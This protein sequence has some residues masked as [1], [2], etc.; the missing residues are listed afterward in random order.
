MQRRE[1]DALVR[2][3]DMILVEEITKVRG[4]LKIILV[5]VVKRDMLIKKVTKN[6]ESPFGPKLLIYME[7]TESMM[8]DMLE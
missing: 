4:G 3:S 1:F 6:I 2:K 7:E 8:L 5:E